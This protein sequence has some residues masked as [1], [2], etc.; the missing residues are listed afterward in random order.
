MPSLNIKSDYLERLL[1]K[2]RAIQGRAGVAV[3]DPGSNPTD[4]DAGAALENRPEYRDDDEVAKEI[5]G[6]N[7]RQSAELLALLWV[8]R[9][10]AEP[11]D[12]QATVER[13]MTEVKT[14]VSDKI[15]KEPLAAEHIEEGIARL[16]NV[17]V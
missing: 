7:D 12:W 9:G 15:L 2:I 8:G 10:I 14:P 13:A 4:D 5:D 17:T 3:A 6:L 16:E 1:L 11:E